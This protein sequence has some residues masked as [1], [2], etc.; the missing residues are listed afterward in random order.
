MRL[1][2]DIANL[3][4][5]AIRDVIWYR[6]NVRT[7]LK[8]CGVG[9]HILAE[10]P[11]N[12]PTVKLVHHVL[13]RLDSLGASG[14]RAVRQMLTR[15]YYWKDIHTVPPDR[16]DQALDS[17]RELQKAYKKHESQLKFQEEKERQMHEERVV[18]TQMKPLDHAKL[19]GFRE[20]F[21]SVHLERDPQLRGNRFEALMNRIFDY[22]A[23]E[24][25]GAF[26]RVGEQLDGQFYFDKHWYYVEV[27]WQEEQTNA[28]DIS[29][30]RDRAKN[31]FGGDTKALFISFNGFTAECLESLKG[32]S[33]ERVILMDGFDLRCVLDCQIAFDVLLAAKQGAKQGEMVRENGRPFVSAKEIIQLRA[34]AHS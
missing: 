16:K 6:N 15:M 10:L 27:R 1:P 4:A 22:Y 25:K 18:R 34:R 20:E 12:T 17:L 32:K 5:V 21:D 8:Q 9:A 29:V 26:R 28:A 2:Q 7:F 14:E 31:S 30:L 13:D 24:S 3:L 19:Q 11:D 33:D 23:E